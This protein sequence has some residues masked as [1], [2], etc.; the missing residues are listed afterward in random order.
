FWFALIKI[1]A[2]CALIVTGAGLVA[3]GFQSPNG[4]V[5]SLANLWNDGGMFPMGLGGFFA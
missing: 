1:V 5:A 2:I 4:S 3:W